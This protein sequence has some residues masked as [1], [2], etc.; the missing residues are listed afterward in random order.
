MTWLPLQSILSVK[1]PRAKGLRL[2]KKG[3]LTLTVWQR[4][5]YICLFLLHTQGTVGL[6]SIIWDQRGTWISLFARG[7]SSVL[8]PFVPYFLIF[9]CLMLIKV[10]TTTKHS[11]TFWIMHLAGFTPNAYKRMY[12][13]GSWALRG[14]TKC[15]RPY[16]ENSIWSMVFNHEAILQ[17]VGHVL[18]FVVLYCIFTCLEKLSKLKQLR[19]NQIKQILKV[20]L[21]QSFET[22]DSFFRIIKFSHHNFFYCRFVNPSQFLEPLVNH[23]F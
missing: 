19:I 1:Q 13:I 5:S 21:N 11:L 10:F 20:Q 17:F 22:H 9:I 4:F 12:Q 2:H 23:N 3:E 6:N 7:W 14:K 16:E 18:C 15:K 8:T